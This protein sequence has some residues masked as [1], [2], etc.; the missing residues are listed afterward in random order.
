MASCYVGGSDRCTASTRTLGTSRIIFSPSKKSCYLMHHACMTSSLILKEPSTG[1]GQSIFSGLPIDRPLGLIPASTQQI[2]GAHDHRLPSDKIYRIR[3]SG[4]W[5]RSVALSI[6]IRTDRR[7]HLKMTFPPKHPRGEGKTPLLR[8]TV[9]ACHRKATSRTIIPALVIF[10][11]SL[12]NWPA[13]L[14][15]LLLVVQHHRCHK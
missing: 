13:A 2:H 14:L 8:V 1:R 12:M 4:T 10:C 9:K 7:A 5:V 6:K 3:M 15:Y 11:N